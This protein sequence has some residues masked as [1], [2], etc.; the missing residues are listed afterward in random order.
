MRFI[1]NRE[2]A[3]A[4]P[5]PVGRYC[6]VLPALLHMQGER[7]ATV[8]SI[9]SFPDNTHK[10]EVD[11][12]SLN[13]L[14][15]SLT[16]STPMPIVLDRQ[17]HGGHFR[18]VLPTMVMLQR[19]GELTVDRVDASSSANYYGMETCEC[20]VSFTVHTYEALS[21]LMEAVRGIDTL[22]RRY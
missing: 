20:T 1:V 16:T 19:H 22:T 3:L 18:D 4:E 8:R 7:N 5:E 14:M 15:D 9:Y 21:R 13:Y 11:M 6:H 2:P 10:I 12:Q 17:M